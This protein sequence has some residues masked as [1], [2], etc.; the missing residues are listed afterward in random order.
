MPPRLR[1]T[2]LRTKPGSKSGATG[3]LA[4]DAG[5]G[6]A[7][8]QLISVRNL[9]EKLGV[10]RK[11]FSRVVGFSERAIADWEADKP[12]SDASLQRM[13]EITRLQ[14][15]LATVMREDFIGEWLN[16]P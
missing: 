4:T 16:T 5:R 9:R 14:Q 8:S 13:R 2:P 3:K 10:N 11:L 6:A 12:L 7:Q 1:R 15:A